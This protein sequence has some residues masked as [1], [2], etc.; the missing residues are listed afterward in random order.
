MQNKEQNFL[1]KKSCHSIFAF[2]EKKGLFLWRSKFFVC[3]FQNRTVFNETEINLTV[4]CFKFIQFKIENTK[5]T[6]LVARIWRTTIFGNLIHRFFI[7][8]IHKLKL[9]NITILFPDFK[10]LI[11]KYGRNKI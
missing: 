5:V 3:Y 6:F 7:F 11:I 8:N 1:F 2:F 9:W 10:R 4:F